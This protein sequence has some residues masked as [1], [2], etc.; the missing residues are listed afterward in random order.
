MPE[1]F[2]SQR[3]KQI[4]AKSLVLTLSLFYTIVMLAAT[5]LVVSGSVAPAIALA[6]T[7]SGA[8]PLKAS[9]SYLSRKKIPGPVLQSE[10]ATVPIMCDHW[11]TRQFEKRLVEAGI[12]EEEDLTL[13]LHPFCKECVG[14][15]N[16]RREIATQKRQLEKSKAEKEKEEV[17]WKE[18]LAK[19]NARRE[20]IKVHA[21]G[22][23]FPW[24]DEVPERAE[25]QWYENGTNTIMV[26][27]TWFDSMNGN[28][29]AYRRLYPVI[30]RMS[31]K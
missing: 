3:E 22:Q 25:Y 23:E 5:V 24:P 2:L 14:T 31:F 13:C 4:M 21:F 20:S 27:F 19:E 6:G 26:I 9:E 30:A 29:M 10:I 12:I 16:K 7:M 8:L 11:E 17:S 1:E 28:R 15:R 18:S